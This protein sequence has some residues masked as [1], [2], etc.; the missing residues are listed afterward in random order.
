VCFA[1]TCPDNA[2]SKDFRDHLSGIARAVHPKIGKLVRR[3]PLRVKGAKTGFIAKEW[4]AGHG[5]A[6][7][8]KKFDGR[9]EPQNGD[10]GVSQKFRT[11][12]LGIRASAER[13]D[14]GFLQFGSA[15]KSG[16]KLVSFDLAKSRFAE[17]FEN[18]RD[19]KSGGLL[20]A[21]IQID[22]TPGQLAGQKSADSRLAGTHE[23]GKAN[24]L[25]ARGGATQ[26]GRLSHCLE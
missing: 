15:P 7:R 11:T 20:D 16:A 3:K 2:A 22:E 1:A 24:D 12:G 18:L 23:A 13:E 21:F 26:R 19:G 9:I 4:T 25:R 8:E 5:H 10:T 6:A 17:A 14:C